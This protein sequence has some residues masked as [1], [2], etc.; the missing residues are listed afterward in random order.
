MDIF[1]TKKAGKKESIYE[2]WQWTILSQQ[3][4]R[5]KPE[6]HWHALHGWLL[7]PKLKPCCPSII[8]G[9]ELLSL[10]RRLRQIPKRTS[11]NDAPAACLSISRIMGPV[12][13][14][15]AA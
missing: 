10:F 5:D 1:E 12:L 14:E 3:F 9:M 11:V 15:Q 8:G 2:F 4:F 7:T 13:S 6:H